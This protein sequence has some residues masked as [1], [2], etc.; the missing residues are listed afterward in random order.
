[1]GRGLGE[2]Q[3]GVLGVVEGG[4]DILAVCELGQFC[5]FD[6]G[7]GEEFGGEF[8]WVGVGGV[9][10]FVCGGELSGG[11]EFWMEREIGTCIRGVAY[12]DSLVFEQ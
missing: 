4:V 9:Y 2:G 5:V 3:G 10:E 11:G 12:G 7:G 6:N 1:M 8:G